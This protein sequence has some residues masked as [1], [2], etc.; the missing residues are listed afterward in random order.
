MPVFRID[1][2]IE[3]DR[4][5]GS[6]IYVQRTYHI[7]YRYGILSASQREAVHGVVG[8]AWHY[9]RRPLIHHHIPHLGLVVVGTVCL[10]SKRGI[11]AYYHIAGLARIAS[12]MGE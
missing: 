8:T 9:Q 6:A 5:I 3:I 7:R 10:F 12:E 4:L 1:T 11:I 2:H